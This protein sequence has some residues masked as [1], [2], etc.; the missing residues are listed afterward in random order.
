MKS[1]RKF[2]A[3]FSVALALTSCATINAPAPVAYSPDEIIAMSTKAGATPAAVVQ[4]LKEGRSY[5]ALP[6][7]ELARMSKAGVA[8][9]VVNHLQ[10]SHLEA[11][12]QAERAQL[13]FE[14]P[15]WYGHF[16]GMRT[17]WRG[18]RGWVTCI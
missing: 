12:R 9:E 5:Y 13:R 2:I 18:A 16:Y 4:K 15:F 7:S 10:A 11:T 3:T 1:I 6:A 8:D 14:S 17:C